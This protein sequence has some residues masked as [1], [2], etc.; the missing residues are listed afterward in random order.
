[1]KLALEASFTPTGRSRHPADMYLLYSFA[2][3]LLFF[4]ALPYFIYQ[5]LR[6][7][8]YQGSFRQRMGFLP[9][10]LK[11]NSRPTIW[12]HT[13]SVGEF[14]AARPLISQ[15]KE[16]LP[17][18]TIVVSTITLTGQRLAASATGSFER[19]F[20]FPFDWNFAV[21][22]SLD[23]INPALVVIL[24]T[25]LWPNFL[26]ECRRRKIVTVIANGRISAGSFKGYRRARKFI[27]RVLADVSLLVMQSE[28]DAERVLKLGAPQPK[29]RICG[30]LK[31]DVIDKSED[32]GFIELCRS[33]DNQFA[34]SASSKLIVAGSTAQG[35]EKIILESL[36]S[37]RSQRGLETVRLLI[38]PRHPERFEEVF[39]LIKQS[40]FSFARRSQPSASSN[41]AD[42]ILLDTIGELNAAYRFASLVF[43]GGSLVAR[44]GHN[45]IEPAACARAIIVGPHMENFRAIAAD[46]INADAM[47]QIKPADLNPAQSLAGEFTQL[48]VDRAAAEAMGARAREILLRNRGTTLCTV[49][50][51]TKALS[52]KPT[53]V[54]SATTSNPL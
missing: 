51:I 31:Y 34:L 1:V 21:R 9:A 7:G 13:V 18:H 17:D 40:G 23:H 53:N 26:R 28:M 29:V 4:A 10:E 52:E 47:I 19:A 39:S 30:N 48:L 36:R 44:G 41:K 50:A 46:F 2:L 22:R 16:S 14:N 45:V 35:E 8:K 54:I 49:E 15:L 32:S 6:H 3:T 20:Y 42:V 43:V 24:E 5:A 38:A 12:V 27:S 33:L 37:V 25:E 11:D